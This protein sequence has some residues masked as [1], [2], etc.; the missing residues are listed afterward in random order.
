MTNKELRESGFLK[1]EFGSKMQEC[2]TAWDHW[3]TELS[4]F[5]FNVSGREYQR[6]RRAANWCQAV[7]PAKGVQSDRWKSCQ[8]SC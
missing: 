2:I 7:R 3:I 1:T 8:I 4:K 6:A 5:A